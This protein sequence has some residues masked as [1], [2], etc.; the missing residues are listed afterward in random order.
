M[1]RLD[2]SFIGRDG[3]IT[4]VAALGAVVLT[5]G[6]APAV[7]TLAVL[8]RAWRSPVFPSA[9]PRRILVLGHRLADGAPSVVFEQRLARAALLARQFPGAEVVLLGG[10]GAPEQP[11]EAEAG[12]D[13]LAARGLDPARIT[14]E[15]DSRHT[16][17]NLHNHRALHG[18]AGPEA[19]VT[20]RCHLHRAMLMANGLGLSPMPVAAEERLRFEPA[21]LLGE[22]FRLH[23]YVTGR[24]LARLLHHRGWLARIS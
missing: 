13:W 4:L 1:S 16:L 17:E 6:L 23:W 14:L 12:R 5:A 19:L 2:G 9:A 10:R 3:T 15:T 22:G 8:R 24:L 20:S 21:R 7:A 11:S 18:T